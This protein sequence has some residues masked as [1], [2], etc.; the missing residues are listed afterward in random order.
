M[1]NLFLL[2]E[3]VEHYD[4][5]DAE[6]LITIIAL[7]IPWLALILYS[8]LKKFKIV[9]HYRY[10]IEGEELIAVQKIKANAP[11]VLPNAPV[12]E[13]YI[14]VGWYLEPELENV[15]PYQTMPGKNLNLYAKWIEK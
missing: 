8:L 11:I 6:I 13:G 3:E 10:E 7:C 14:F 4:Y 9:Y 5:T 12:R 1:N 15:F 2:L